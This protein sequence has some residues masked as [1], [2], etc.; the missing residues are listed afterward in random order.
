MP[1]GWQEVV[2]ISVV[3]VSI[4]ACVIGRHFASAI[5]WR[6]YY[7]ARGQEHGCDHETEAEGNDKS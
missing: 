6:G 5:K 2:T 7:Q 4:A 3:V 1:G